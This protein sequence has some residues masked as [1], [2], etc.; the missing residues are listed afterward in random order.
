MGTA[1][2]VDMRRLRALFEGLGFKKVSTYINSG[3]VIFSGAGAASVLRERIAAA[4]KAEFGF[5]VAVLVK[6][7]AQMRGIARAIPAGWRNDD[8]QR[9]DVAYLFGEADKA[10][11]LAK[12]PFNREAVDARYVKG[13]VIWNLDRKDYSRSRLNKLIGSELYKAMTLR[14]VNTARFLAGL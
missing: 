3:N 12:L 5:E 11:S 8:E 10:A 13:A 2:K 7:R 4:V 9:T 14:N 6:T 1:R